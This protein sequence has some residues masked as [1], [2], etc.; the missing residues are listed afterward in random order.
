M[1]GRHSSRRSSKRV[2]G[3]LPIMAGLLVLIVV[4][5][6]SFQFLA[7]QLGDD[8][9]Q[10]PTRVT[11][12]A[13]PAVAPVL[14]E[15]AGRL[16]RADD[17]SA[18]GCYR[19]QVLSIDSATVA[20]RLTGVED[21]AIPDVWVPDSTYW[22]NR[23]RA[24]GAIDLPEAGASI[25]SSPVV[26]AVVEPGAA[27]LGWPDKQLSWADVFADST[28]GTLNI[29]LADPARNPV[30]LA[31]LFGVR[32]VTAKA[33][34]PP[35]AQVEALRRLS[36]NVVSEAPHLL[37]GLPPAHD[38]SALAKSLGAFPTSEQTVLRHNAQQPAQQPTRRLVPIY[39]DPDVP[40]LDYPYVVLSTTAGEQ[41]DA[42]ER[43]LSELL[44]PRTRD[45]LQARGLR[46][47]DGEA[48]ADFPDG[49]DRSG[50]PP[51]TVAATPLPD[52]ADVDTALTTWAGV[53]LSARLVTAIDVSGS[54][55]AQIPGTSNS[56][57][58]A[59]VQAAKQGLGLFK[60][61]TDLGLWAFSDKLGGAKPYR[62]LAPIGPLSTQRQ[63]LISVADT[64]PPLTG[65]QTKLY[66]TVLAAYETVKQGW[67]PARLNVVVI[68]TDGLDDDV[69]SVTREQLISELT[70]Q[71]DPLRP[72]RVIFVGIGPD[73][74]SDG[75]DEIAAVT[76]G[77]A[78]TTE[79]PAGINDVFAAA[80][81]E[82]TCIP[83]DCERN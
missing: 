72:L 39:P 80:L 69:S 15:V 79:D 52:A 16:V 83:P 22:L 13:D 54:M 44:G 57:I 8:G 21:G 59:T 35:A 56:R 31:G 11:V 2:A 37:E 25:A 46:T 63:K 34:H 64:I 66:D 19:V 49:D 81:A 70:K 40:V 60:D 6:F 47:A 61:T 48:G 67:D 38:P 24:G 62:E 23:A 71:H 26:L 3:S 73:V 30:G 36:P 42:A 58:A 41:R 4:A 53:N 75:L 82:L 7:D 29:G 10:A 77:R 74:H 51:A 43:F 14:A 5:W 27:R 65:G 1:A 17:R 33:A 20:D 32:A 68:L 9:C 55:W 45:A 28:A 76:G 50:Q 12:T 18:A 78:F